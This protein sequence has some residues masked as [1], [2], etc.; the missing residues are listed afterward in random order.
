MATP[1]AS[2]SVLFSQWTGNL[3]FQ[4]LTYLWSVAWVRRCGH[5]VVSA[6]RL[7]IVRMMMG[8]LM[9]VWV[10]RM[11]IWDRSVGGKCPWLWLEKVLIYL[12]TWG[13]VAGMLRVME[14]SVV[15]LRRYPELHSWLEIQE[16]HLNETSSRFLRPETWKYILIHSATTLLF[17]E[18]LAERQKQNVNQSSRPTIN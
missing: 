17:I 11:M 14:A 6:N 16:D 10:I 3:N 8:I 7:E 12:G 2:L 9:M 5:L 1:E 15:S 13:K 4:L 18:C